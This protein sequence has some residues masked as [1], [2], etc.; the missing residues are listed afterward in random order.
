MKKKLTFI[1]F[2]LSF[3][4]AYSQSSIGDN[5]YFYM[6]ATKS[7]EMKNGKVDFIEYKKIKGIKK[8]II[9]YYSLI[10][11]KDISYKTVNKKINIHFFNE[12]DSILYL[13]DDDASYLIDYKK[14][15]VLINEKDEMIFLMRKN[16]PFANFYSNQ[17][18]GDLLLIGRIRDSI[19][20]DF[21]T[22]V[23]FVQQKIFTELY[24]LRSKT[25]I[26]DERLF[27]YDRYEFRN[28]DTL[29]IQYVSRISNPYNYEK[30]TIVEIETKL[31][32]AVLDDI[33]YEKPHYYNYEEFCNDDF[34]F[35]DK[36]K[37]LVV[38]D[39][40]YHN[41]NLER[42]DK[43]ALQSLIAESKEGDIYSSNF[44]ELENGMMSL[45]MRV[46]EGQQQIAAQK[47][48]WQEIADNRILNLNLYTLPTK[49]IESISYCDMEM[50]NIPFTVP[51]ITVEIIED[52]YLVEIQEENMIV[53][54]A[55]FPS[56]NV[57]DI[58]T[59]T[60]ALLTEIKFE[61]FLLEEFVEE[62]L[63]DPIEEIFVEETF[64]EDEIADLIL[65]DTEIEN[66]VFEEI[67]TEEIKK[68]E[69]IDTVILES[70][71]SIDIIEV[72]FDTL[73]K[74][75]EIHIET[76]ALTTFSDE[77]TE[78]T[79][80]IAENMEIASTLLEIP[81][82]VEEVKVE[83]IFSEP[84]S[85]KDSIIEVL[86][87]EPIYYIVLNYFKD[88]ENARAFFNDKNKSYNNLMHLGKDLS[89]GTFMV[90]IGPYQTEDEVQNRVENLRINGVRGWILIQ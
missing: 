21:S 9:T 60:I 75:D 58:V 15:E 53:D 11:A 57:N 34:H 30:G 42:D 89:S 64:I 84:S 65:L 29:M 20:T 59:D 41:E 76:I 83:L 1:L 51:L 62:A 24:N 44:L 54:E 16:Y 80:D 49:Y 69:I 2:L 52:K 28:T 33:E 47:K 50:I 17:A 74:E 43:A 4:L 26:S 70:L 32:Y 46:K 12:Q 88:I 14:K 13:V 72:N 67:P 39:Y 5:P 87:N 19:K 27:C 73:K 55:N 71:A 37:S 78:D 56:E 61:D 10:F 86:E 25:S 36:R 8:P 38:D 90:G 18:G 40:I 82:V 6:L 7:Q 85:E 3:S 23:S 35:Y 68:E 45:Y 77:V 31:L 22:V 66:I 79:L 81:I 63:V 48:E